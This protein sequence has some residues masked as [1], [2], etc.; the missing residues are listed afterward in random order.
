MTKSSSDYM[1]RIFLRAKIMDHVD[2]RR[3]LGERCDS[4][5]K[6][7]LCHN[8]LS[9]YHVIVSGERVVGLVGWGQADFVPTVMEKCWYIFS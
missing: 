4:Q 3:S 6:P 5:D 1:N 8:N 2:R 9:P 7:T